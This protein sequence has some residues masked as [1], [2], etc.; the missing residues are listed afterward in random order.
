MKKYGI[1]I[2]NIGI[3]FASIEDR[4]KALVDFTKGSDVNISDSGIIYSDGKGNF[5]VYD[6]D[7]KEILTRCVS[8]EGTFSIESCPKRDYPYKYYG[9]TK[10]SETSDHIC[11]ACL[12]KK[13]KEKEVEEAKAVLKNAESD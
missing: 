8:C 3:E 13:L 7:T 9:Q 2:G 11:D 10:Y 12:A 6:R 5:S 4:T 1:R